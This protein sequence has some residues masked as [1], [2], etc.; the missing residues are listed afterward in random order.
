MLPNLGLKSWAT[1]RNE[2][3]GGGGNT[4]NWNDWVDKKYS[5]ET[6]TM[7]DAWTRLVILLFADPHLLEC[8]K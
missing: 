4:L 5:L 1:K 6:F 3:N 2:M 8:G 7:N